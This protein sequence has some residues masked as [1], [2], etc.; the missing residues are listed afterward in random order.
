MVVKELLTSPAI[1]VHVPVK[2]WVKGKRALF[3]HLEA[4]PVITDHGCLR[5]IMIQH[6]SLGKKSPLL[7][8]KGSLM[9][10]EQ[11]QKW[12]VWVADGEGSAC[13]CCMS[14]YPVPLSL[15]TLSL[16]HPP[17]LSAYRD[18]EKKEEG[19]AFPSS[20]IAH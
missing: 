14:P 20:C 10:F 12:G 16:I 8:M 4:L 2:R 15:T 11:E 9:P 6:L 17:L 3:S 5:P 7:K 1:F 19:L 18:S 13:F